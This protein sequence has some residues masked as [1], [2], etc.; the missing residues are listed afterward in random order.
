MFEEVDPNMFVGNGLVHTLGPGR[1]RGRAKKPPPTK[2]KDFYDQKL[3]GKKAGNPPLN[4]GTTLDFVDMMM[5]AREAKQQMVQS[6]M[7]LV[8]SIARK[9]CNVGV[10]LQDLIQEGSLGLSRA[11]EKFDPGKG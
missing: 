4:R 11:A 9:Y 7:R 1:G 5:D 3:G 6:N 10:S 2:L 8:V